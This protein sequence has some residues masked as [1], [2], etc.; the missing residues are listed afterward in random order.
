MPRL[1]DETIET[2]RQAV[3]QAI[4]DAAW[5]LAVED[6]LRSVTMARIAETAGIGR[7]TLYKYF[8]D[9]ESILNAWHDQHV[10]AHLEELATLGEGPGAPVDRLAAVLEAYGSIVHRRRRHEAELATMLHRPEQIDGPQRQLQ[11]LFRRVLSAAADAGEVRTDIAVSELARYCC[12]ALGAAAGATTEQ[13]VRH[14]V[15]LVL[16]GLGVEGRTRRRRSS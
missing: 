6:G 2:H 14:L 13:S 12:H 3:R 16:A 4:M 1:W 8:H 7:A 10:T 15:E 5:S 9:V 11:D